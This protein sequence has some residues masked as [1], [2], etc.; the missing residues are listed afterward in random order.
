MKDFDSESYNTLL[1]LEA[2]CCLCKRPVPVEL[3]AVRQDLKAQMPAKSD[4]T[5]KGT[6]WRCTVFGSTVVD[7]PA[8]P[9]AAATM[10]RTTFPATCSLFP[11]VSV[12]P[13][14]P[15]PYCRR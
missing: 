4:A 15:R 1:E 2:A 9:G 14:G 12:L 13:L 8:E 3:V 7:S 10:V 5:W 6:E 11:C